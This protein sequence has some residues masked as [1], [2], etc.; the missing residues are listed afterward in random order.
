MRVVEA[1][2]PAFDQMNSEDNRH[3][4]QEIVPR[5]R[6][7]VD[8]FAANMWLAEP[9]TRE[10]FGDLVAFVD[11]WERWINKTLPVEVLRELHHSEAKL[12]PFYE[13]LARQLD[14]LRQRLQS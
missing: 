7:M 5:Y 1:Y 9:E 13:D 14:A 12:L 11:I 3:F 8:H 4:V 2:G 10:Y 6:K